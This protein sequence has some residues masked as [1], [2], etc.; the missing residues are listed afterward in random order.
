MRLFAL[1]SVEKSASALKA[2]ILVEVAQVNVKHQKHTR[3]Q[4]QL[5]EARGFFGCE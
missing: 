2:V 5:R 3:H 4:L 1:H